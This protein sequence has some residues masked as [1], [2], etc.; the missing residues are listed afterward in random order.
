[1][2]QR[3]GRRRRRSDP[4]TP[5]FPLSSPGFS[6]ADSSARRQ[7][8]RRR[9]QLGDDLQ[10][11]ERDDLEDEEEVQESFYDLTYEKLDDLLNKGT[12]IDKRLEVKIKK[13]FQQFLLKFKPEGA[14]TAR[15]PDSLRKM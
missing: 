7:S 2:D 6:D 9:T 15:Y 12:G 8:K 4:G 10:P 13:C 1:M 5:G 11:S 14:Q 3:D